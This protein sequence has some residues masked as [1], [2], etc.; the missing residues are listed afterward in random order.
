MKLFR[1]IQRL[2]RNKGKTIMQ[3]QLQENYVQER[4]SRN[5]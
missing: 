1:L 5:L 4:K 3:G 2:L